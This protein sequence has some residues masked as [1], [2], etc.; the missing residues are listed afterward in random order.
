MNVLPRCLSKPASQV[1]SSQGFYNIITQSMATNQNIHA[2]GT[3]HGASH[4]ENHIMS[5]CDT[6]RYSGPVEQPFFVSPAVP[7]LALGRREETI[8]FLSLRHSLV[9]YGD[10][11]K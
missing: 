3:K 11:G 4:R 1:C 8:D 5:L 9:K 6:H 10:G 7:N 2:I